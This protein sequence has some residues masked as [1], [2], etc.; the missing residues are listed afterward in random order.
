MLP[1]GMCVLGVFIIGPK[2][3][4]DNADDVQKLKSVI[5]AIYKTLSGNN[6]YLYGNNQ[7]EKLI[8]NF[9]SISHKYSILKIYILHYNLITSI[10]S[11]TFL[12]L[13]M[14]VSQ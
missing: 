13:D 7:D 9:N 5:N 3:T 11:L 8:L 14:S 6:K 10:I 12:S 1:G 4:L 2:D